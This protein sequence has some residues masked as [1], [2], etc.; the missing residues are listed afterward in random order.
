MTQTPFEKLSGEVA[1]GYRRR[2]KSAAVAHR[3]GDAVAGIRAR[4]QGKAP[5]GPHYAEARAAN[6]RLHAKG[7]KRHLPARLLKG[8]LR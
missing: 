5:G 6:L 4:A 3:I 1:A 8:A 2:G 7:K